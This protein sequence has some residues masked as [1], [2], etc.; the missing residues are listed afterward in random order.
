[1]FPIVLV[2]LVEHLLFTELQ[3]RVL[4]M[5]ISEYWSSSKSVKSNLATFQAPSA[6]YELLF[7]YC[8][9]VHMHKCGFSDHT[10][11]WAL[12][13]EYLVFGNPRWVQ[14]RADVMVCLTLSPPAVVGAPRSFSSVSRTHLSGYSAFKKHHIT[15]K[16]WMSTLQQQEMLYLIDI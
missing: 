4:H 16:W 13:Q 8:G 5:L 2:I 12:F 9:R 10:T 14:I 6:V 11:C 3:K 7:C 15:E 1:M